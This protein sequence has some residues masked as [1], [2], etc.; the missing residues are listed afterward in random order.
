MI[1]KNTEVNSG[2]PTVNNV[3]TCELNSNESIKDLYIDAK[4]RIYCFA[5]DSKL[6]TFF[7]VNL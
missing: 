2:M 5:G 4:P 7:I 6:V 1:A 3:S